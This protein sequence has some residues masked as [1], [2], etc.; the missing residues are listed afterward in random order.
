MANRA[1]YRLAASLCAAPPCGS[2]TRMAASHRSFSLR[3]SGRAPSSSADPDVA[4]GQRSGRATAEAAVHAWVRI[5]GLLGRRRATRCSE[6]ARRGRQGGGHRA[7]HA[8]HSRRPRGR[9]SVDLDPAGR[10]QRATQQDSSP[11]AGQR[12]RALGQRGL[13]VGAPD[14]DPSRHQAGQGKSRRRGTIVSITTAA[15]SFKTRIGGCFSSC[16]SNE[17][18]R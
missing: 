13:T 5:F 3:P 18:T 9:R 7:P 15:T 11:H 1:P 6:R 10:T 8:L 12:R 16:L 4:I 2:E 17:T 14:P